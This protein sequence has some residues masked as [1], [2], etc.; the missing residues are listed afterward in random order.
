MTNYDGYVIKAK[1]LPIIEQK[2]LEFKLQ[3]E[4]PNDKSYFFSS[5]FCSDLSDENALKE[6]R[7]AMQNSDKIIFYHSSDISDLAFDS[8]MSYALSKPLF[9]V[10]D[11]IL[12][13]KK[14]AANHHPDSID[15]VSQYLLENFHYLPNDTFEKVPLNSIKNSLDSSLY[16]ESK[17]DNDSDT[18]FILGMA[19][20]M[21]KV[22][23]LENKK[24]LESSK[25]LPVEDS[26]IKVPEQVLYSKM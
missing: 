10:N 23:N 22:I 2:Y 11:N 12:S 1:E 19:Y 4:F 8:G 17:N 13:E 14:H 3:D 5:D 9:L 24:P 20:M 6:K 16:L 26:F 25:Y 15:L 21:G 7:I 18:L